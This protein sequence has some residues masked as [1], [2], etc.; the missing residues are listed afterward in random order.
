MMSRLTDFD[1]WEKNFSY[2]RWR[3]EEVGTSC[4][5]VDD[6]LANLRITIEDELQTT[7]ASG[8]RPTPRHELAPGSGQSACL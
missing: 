2:E 8:I 7:D 6:Y 4:H 3:E 1:L 5:F